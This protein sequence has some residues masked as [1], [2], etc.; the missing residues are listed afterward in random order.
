[1]GKYKNLFLKKSGPE[2]SIMHYPEKWTVG[3]LKHLVIK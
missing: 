3:I 2:H 1:M